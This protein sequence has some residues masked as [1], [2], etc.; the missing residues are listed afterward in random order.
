MGICEF[1]RFIGEGRIHPEHP[2]LG[3]EATFEETL[4]PAAALDLGRLV[5]FHAEENCG[6]THDELLR[7]PW[8][9]ERAVTLVGVGARSQVSQ[10]APA[11]LLGEGEDATTA[12]TLARPS[13]EPRGRC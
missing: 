13:R 7:T 4:A 3:F 2:V 8:R 5:L 9:L 6:L 10:P 12:T 1:D 11:A